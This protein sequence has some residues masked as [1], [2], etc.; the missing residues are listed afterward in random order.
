MSDFID[1]TVSREAEILGAAV[2]NR[3]KYQGF[4]AHECETCGEP[5]P[6]ARRLALPGCVL[7]VDCASRKEARG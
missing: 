2:A 3:V 1:T 5:I 4:S 7:C 6:E